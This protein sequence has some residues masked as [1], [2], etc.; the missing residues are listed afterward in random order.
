MKLISGGKTAIGQIFTEK[1]V[2]L[3]ASPDDGTRLLVMRFWPRG[4]KRGQ[5]GEWIRDLAPSPGLL[6][7]CLDHEGELDPDIYANTWKRRYREEMAGQK[8][9]IEDLCERLRSGESLTL[10]CAC[11]DPAKCH[12]TVLAEIIGMK[13]ISGGG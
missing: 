12:R 4:V 1:H 11:H 13:F 2:R 3:H 5:I 6:S 7:W 8:D 9:V 10:L